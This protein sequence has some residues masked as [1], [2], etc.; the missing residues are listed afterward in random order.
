M[1]PATMTT[2]FLDIGNVLLTKDEIWGE[3]R[4]LRPLPSPQAP[5]PTRRQFAWEGGAKGPAFPGK[6]KFVRDWGRGL[7]EG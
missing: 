1:S 3:G 5:L 2:I 4:D 6:I 7:G